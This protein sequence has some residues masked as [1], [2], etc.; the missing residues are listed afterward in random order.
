MG[1]QAV[2]PDSRTLIIQD[3]NDNAR[4]FKLTKDHSGGAHILERFNSPEMAPD[5]NATC[6]EKIEFEKFQTAMD[7]LTSFL[8]A[9][10]GSGVDVATPGMLRAL[11]TTLDAFINNL[12]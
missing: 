3:S 2:R 1:L 5:E 10:Y 8:V 12:G 7:V 11:E 4:Y 9:M 6:E